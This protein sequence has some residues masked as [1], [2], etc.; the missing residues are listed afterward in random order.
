MSRRTTFRKAMLSALHYSGAG[1]MIAPLTRG[2]GAI[3][4]LH[5]VRPEKPGSFEPN[6]TLN[7][8]PDFLEQVITQVIAS[9]LDRKSTRLNSS[10]P[11]ISY[12]VFCLKKK[13][14]K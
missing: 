1:A 8:T 7:V 2:I 6:R 12:A 14:T 13:K 10:H 4:M 11:S 5:H 9:G 3:F